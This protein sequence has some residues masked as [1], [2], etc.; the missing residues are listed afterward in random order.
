MLI[1]TTTNGRH[2]IKLD[3]FGGDFPSE[4]TYARLERDLREQLVVLRTFAVHT[5]QLLAA[6]ASVQLAADEAGDLV[7]IRHAL[8]VVTTWWVVSQGPLGLVTDDNMSLEAQ[9]GRAISVVHARSFA[10]NEADAAQADESLQIVARSFYMYGTS[11]YGE[12]DGE[13]RVETIPVLSEA[14]SG[15]VIRAAEYLM[16]RLIV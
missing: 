1:P 4:A 12:H 3:L 15:R 5:Q 6:H 8:D 16:N 14:D 13:P 10:A 11:V 7:E 9:L 2:A